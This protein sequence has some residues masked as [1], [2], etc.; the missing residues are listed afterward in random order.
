M[1]GYDPDQQREAGG[2]REI[3]AVTGVVFGMLIPV[4]IAL[5]G[6]LGLIISVF[7]LVEFHPLLALLPFAPLVGGVVWMVNHD[8]RVRREMEEELGETLDK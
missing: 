1:Y 6:C 4:F 8:R 3:F 2:C 7:Y 5:A